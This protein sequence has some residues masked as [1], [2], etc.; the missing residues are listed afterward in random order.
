MPAPHFCPNS[1]VCATR[2]LPRAA[3]FSASVLLVVLGFSDAISQLRCLQ[4]ASLER[5]P[6]V[7]VR[8]ASRGASPEYRL[9]Y[10]F[11]ANQDVHMLL[12]VNAQIRVQKNQDIT[13]T[14][15]QAIT[16]RHYHVA[17]V[18]PDGSAVLELFIDNAKLSLSF[19][20]DPAITYDTKFALIAPRE[21]GN[22]H[23]SIGKMMARMKVN[24]RGRLISVSDSQLGQLAD[25]SQSFLDALPDK[26]VH[27]GDQWFDDITVKVSIS[28]VLKEK[29][30]LR[31][32]YTL[33]SVEGS[34][35]KI[36]VAT[37]ELTPVN[38]P[39]TAAQLLSLTPE[40]LIQFDMDKGLVKQRELRCMRTETG[41]MGEGS[42]IAG[43]TSMK[44]SLR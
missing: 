36:R 7:A 3:I 12:D 26:P 31:R 4:A 41:I 44:G 30:T 5:G 18:E 23:E 22:V 19:N 27:V 14:S 39:Q 1:R 17:S 15:H 8:P 33:D 11:Q 13:N 25:P 40:G 16:E 37:A 21:F 24:A 29:I 2:Q 10:K 43:T 6:V 38:D 9:A 32:R 34:I 42:V 35:A 28:K 20:N